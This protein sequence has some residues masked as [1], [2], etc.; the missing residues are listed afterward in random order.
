MKL[1][2]FHV[3][4]GSLHLLWLKHPRMSSSF[5]VEWTT[6]R[7]QERKRPGS[8]LGELIENHIKERWGPDVSTGGLPFFFILVGTLGTFFG[9]MHS[10][11]KGASSIFL[12]SRNDFSNHGFLHPP[13]NYPKLSCLLPAEDFQLS[14]GNN[15]M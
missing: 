3:Y 6:L 7:C 15:T 5:R 14:R 9:W 12:F 13:Q 8:E 2:C 11:P 10:A 4:S 1:L